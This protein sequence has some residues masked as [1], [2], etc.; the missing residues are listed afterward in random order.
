[1]FNLVEARPIDLHTLPLW[2]GPAEQAFAVVVQDFALG[3]I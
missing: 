3:L 1:M 2:L